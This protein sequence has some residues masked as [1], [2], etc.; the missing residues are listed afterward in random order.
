MAVLLVL[1][2]VPASAQ[3]IAPHTPLGSIDLYP[4]GSVGVADAVTWKDVVYV[5]SDS[6]NNLLY[7]V[8]VSNPSSP[9]YVARALNMGGHTHQPVVVEDRLY[10][11]AWYS[12]LQILDVSAGSMTPLG[13]YTDPDGRYFWGVEVSNN[14]AYIAQS[15]DYELQSFQ[16]VDV[17]DPES[18]SLV[19]KIPVDPRLVFGLAVRGSYAYMANNSHLLTINISDERNPFIARDQDLGYLLGGVKLKGNYVY[20]ASSN[21]NGGLFVMDVSNPSSPVQVGH[22]DNVGGGPMC[23]LGDYLFIGGG[24]LGMVT[25]DIS[26]P[27]SPHLATTTY[28]DS[29]TDAVESYEYSVTGNGRFVYVGTGEMYWQTEPPHDNYWKGKLYSFEAFSEDPD[30]EGPAKWS[31][32]TPSEASWD[33][34][35]EAD[36]LPTASTPTWTVF[37]GSTSWASVSGGVLRIND[38]GTASGEKVKFSRNWDATNCRGGTVLVRARCALYNT[39]GASIPNVILSDGKYNVEFAILSDKFRCNTSGQEFAIDGAAWHTYR[40][41]TLGTQFRV[42]VDESPAAALTGSLTQTNPDARWPRV[43]FG[44]GSSPAT[45]DIYFDYLYAFSNGSCGPS[46]ATTDT[47]P[48]VS[49]RVSDVP[50]AGSVS[51]IRPNTARVH[52]STDGGATWQQS[53]GVAWDH[54]YNADKLPSISTPNWAL[55]EGSEAYGSVSSGVLR[56]NDSSTGSNTKVKWSRAWGASSYTGTTT[57]VRARCD[58]AGGNT[59]MLGN[60]FIEDGSRLEMF[61]IMTDRV[62]AKYAN[63]TYMLDGTQWHVYRITTKNAS[64]KLYVDENPTP[65]LSGTLGST[66]TG[67]RIMFGSGASAATQDISFD[68][69]RYTTT[70]ELPPGQG[71][72]GGSVAVSCTGVY[73]DDRG[74][75]SAYGIPFNQCSET[76]NKV[77]FSLRDAKGNVGYSPVYNVRVQPPLGPVTSFRAYGQAGAVALS[78]ADPAD[79]RF[80]GTMIRWKTGSYP[81][82]PTDG[83][84]LY[85]GTATGYT[86]SGRANGAKYYYSAFT[87]DAYSNY[88]SAANAAAHAAIDATTAQAKSLANGQVRALRGCV[89]SAVYA[90]C[91][92]VQ[93][94]GRPWG[95]KVIA[96][97][98]VSVGQIVDVVGMLTGAGLERALDT[99]GNAVKVIP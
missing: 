3:L 70:G 45:Q 65:A 39:H 51:G 21:G 38:T 96:P 76:L 26:S 61:A 19:S 24:G 82:G 89:V 29:L 53:G 41:T 91:F 78:W 35:Y 18:P 88:S 40:I 74:A 63:L 2:A 34:Q 36:A 58:A 8:D 28:V 69:V 49:V 84:L 81:T 44:S 23:I 50:Y 46:A 32:F 80:A 25:V 90:D 71:D 9:R 52:W 93:E 59:S 55:Y 94:P 86:H 77:K 13:D 68:Y 64:F 66:A 37:E 60:V 72:G 95:I 14:R 33:T 42:Y 7:S 30:T 62:V 15:D 85:D 17:S 98:A 97:D 67:N 92:Y 48:D 54:E 10:L 87:H 11:A 1:A 99:Q 75:I 47:T 79:A 31:G 22:L 4:Y 12:C 73:G 57:V 27:T 56:V 6:P 20:T 16:I 43:I 83:A 5:S